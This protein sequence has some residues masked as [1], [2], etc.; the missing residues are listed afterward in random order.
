MEGVASSQAIDWLREL[1]QAV[2]RHPEGLRRTIFEVQAVDWEAKAA[3][4][5]D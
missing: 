1:V 5:R 2:A 3:P 4:P